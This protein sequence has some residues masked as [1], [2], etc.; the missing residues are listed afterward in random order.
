MPCSRP[1]LSLLATAAALTVLLACAATPLGVTQDALSKAKDKS[2]KGADV[3]E[4]ECAACHGRKGE[5]LSS[6][7]TVMGGTALPTY[8]RDASTARAAASQEQQ[9]LEQLKPPGQ[10]T[11][12]PFHTAQDLFEY[13]SRWMPLPKARM[14]TLSDEE[15][16][17]VVHFMLVAHGSAV[18]PEGVTP[19]NAKTIKVPPP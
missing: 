12:K 14:G 17:A 13:V 3:Y 9:E 1:S 5:G 10:Q 6:A 16:W 7:P 8:A 11:R 18:P 4:K 15:Y 2:P 19:E